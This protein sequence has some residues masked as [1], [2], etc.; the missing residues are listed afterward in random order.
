MAV[1]QELFASERT[2]NDPLYLVLGL[3]YLGYIQERKGEFE[4]SVANLKKAIELAEAIPIH[5]SRVWMATY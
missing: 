3:T 5:L 4:E 1:T 2:R